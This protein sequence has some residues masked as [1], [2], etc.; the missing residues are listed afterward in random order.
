VV[1]A[2]RGERVF[3]VRMWRQGGDDPRGAWRG[4]VFEIGTETR[5]Y[6]SGARDVA[7]FIDM[8]LSIEPDSN[9]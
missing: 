8:R 6:V 5:F 2:E 3:L 4:S 7:D 1:K 9:P